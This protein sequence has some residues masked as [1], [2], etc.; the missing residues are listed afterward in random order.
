[1]VSHQCPA[2]ITIFKKILKLHFKNKTPG[3]RVWLR[4]EGPGFDSQ[5]CQNRYINNKFPTP[6]PFT[7]KF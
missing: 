2:T 1:V 3:L 7:R 6:P 4:L 5:H